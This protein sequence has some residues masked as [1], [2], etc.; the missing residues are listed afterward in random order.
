MGIYRQRLKKSLKVDFEE[1]YVVNARFVSPIR[2][3][4]GRFR[5]KVDESVPRIHAV[6]LRIVYHAERDRKSGAWVA[7]TRAEEARGPRT[8]SHTSPVTQRTRRKKSTNTT[9]GHNVYD[10]SIHRTL[11]STQRMIPSTYRLSR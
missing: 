4:R 1:P 6:N 9:P 7:T 11:P 5:A 3:A 2:C 10:T 8:Q